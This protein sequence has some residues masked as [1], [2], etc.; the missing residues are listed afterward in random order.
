LLS[1][2]ELEPDIDSRER[3]AVAIR[4]SPGDRHG[5]EAWGGRD[6][7]AGKGHRESDEGWSVKCGQSHGQ[8]S[9]AIPADTAVAVCVSRGDDETSCPVGEYVTMRVR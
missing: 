9:T 4:D 3:W 6:L 5:P 2:L 7:R 8:N 1:R